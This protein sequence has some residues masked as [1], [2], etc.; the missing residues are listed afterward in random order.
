M[1]VPVFCQFSCAYR[2]TLTYPTSHVKLNYLTVSYHIVSSTIH[3]NVVL[4]VFVQT[5]TK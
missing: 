2:P 4:S 3:V 1:T 5:T